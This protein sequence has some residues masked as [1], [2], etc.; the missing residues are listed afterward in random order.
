MGLAGTEV[1]TPGRRRQQ[2]VL[3]AFTALLQDGDPD[4]R[5]A[6]AVSLGQTRDPQGRSPLMTA[7]SD[8]DALVRHAATEALLNLGLE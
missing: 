4:L 7:L 5:L 2:V 1:A 3:G 6:A 8:T